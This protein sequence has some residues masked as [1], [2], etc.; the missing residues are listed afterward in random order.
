LYGRDGASASL[1]EVVKECQRIGIS[2]SV[3]GR[4]QAPRTEPLDETGQ[5]WGPIFVGE[6]RDGKPLVI[7]E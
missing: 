4:F 7:A 3:T 1:A 2:L 5:G 6:L